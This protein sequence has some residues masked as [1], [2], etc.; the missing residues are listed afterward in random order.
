[1]K[2]VEVYGDRMITLSKRKSGI[3]KQ[4][5]EIVSIC[6]VETSFLVFSKAEKFCTFAHLSLEEAAGRLKSPLRHDPSMSTN[7]GPLMEAYKRQKIED[8]RKKYIDL[9]EEL[10]MEN[11]KENI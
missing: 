7:I 3:F 8:L 6:N 9:V 4:M 5:N 2:K 11:E 1:M 10:Q